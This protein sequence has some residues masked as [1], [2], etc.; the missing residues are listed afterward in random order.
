M[1]EITH[2][3]RHHCTVWD[4]DEPEAGPAKGVDLGESAALSSVS[5]SIRQILLVK[6]GPE[7]C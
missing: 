4:C 1:E 5:F 2:V 6:Q 3:T 7:V